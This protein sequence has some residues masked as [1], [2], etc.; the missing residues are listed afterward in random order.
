MFTLDMF[1][2]F[3]QMA[4]ITFF[5][6]LS[7]TEEIEDA[8]IAIIEG[9]VLEEDEDH[10]V[11]TLKEIRKRSKRVYALGTCAV[12]GGI[13]NLNKDKQGIPV[14][15]YIEIDGSIPGCP[16][17]P[18]LLGNALMNILENKEIVL[19]K[20]NLCNKCPLRSSLDYNFQN[21]INTLIPIKDMTKSDT[22]TCFLKD[23]ILCLGPIT[24]EGCESQCIKQGVPCEGC[25][26]P[27]KADFTSNIINFLSLINFSKDLQ[28]YTGIF[29][30][31]SRPK[32]RRITK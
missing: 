15:K 7:D 23:G 13:V 25:L 26:G 1:K 21:E 12:F 4:D 30:R 16:P 5:P 2:Q 24:R 27:I 14:S 31:F 8:D 17:P 11:K 18:K 32:I 3:M 22:P 10:Q 9:S 29:F 28:D 19:S 6:F 20:K